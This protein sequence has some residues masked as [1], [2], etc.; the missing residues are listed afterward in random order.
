MKLRVRVF[1][2]SKNNKITIVKGD[3]MRIHVTEKPISGKANQA[4]I[5][6]ISKSFGVRKSDII[7]HSGERNKNKTFILLGVDEIEIR[8]KISDIAGQEP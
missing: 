4:A 3:E 5:R 2:G 6:L 8:K 7:I 1:P